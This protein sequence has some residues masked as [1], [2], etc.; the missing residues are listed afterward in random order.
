MSRLVFFFAIDRTLT[1]YC[2]DLKCFVKIAS[3][4][5]I[6]RKG[7]ATDWTPDLDNQ[8]VSWV[9]Q[10]I[11]WLETSKT[12]IGESE[13]AKCVVHGHDDAER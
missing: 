10:Y 11:Q 1:I 6:F 5:L 2:R 8:M 7:N 12:G 4:I 9:Q 13:A 3:A